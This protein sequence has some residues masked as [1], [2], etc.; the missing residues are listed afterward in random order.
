MKWYWQEIF[1]EIKVKYDVDESTN[2][3]E[4]KRKLSPSD[5]HRLSQAIKYPN[6][7]FNN[8]Y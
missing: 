7:R 6:G 3:F 2:V 4:L 5:W 1:A 8:G